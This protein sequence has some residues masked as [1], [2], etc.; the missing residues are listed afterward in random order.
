MEKLLKSHGSENVVFFSLRHGR[1]GHAADVAG[2][3][4]AGTLV[5]E[6]GKLKW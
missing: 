1:F 3:S 6:I 5:R 4:N 2:C